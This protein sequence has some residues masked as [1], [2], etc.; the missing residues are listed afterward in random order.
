MKQLIHRDLLT[1]RNVCQILHVLQI[2]VADAKKPNLACFSQ[3]NE[4]FKSLLQ[5][6]TATPM[7]QIKIEAISSLSA[8]AALASGEGA[9]ARG[10]LRQ[11]LAHQKYALPLAFNG[12]TDQF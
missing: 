7:Q 8:Q 4:R 6:K 9:L 3:L 11:N 1:P 12:F 10:I 5:W 2:K